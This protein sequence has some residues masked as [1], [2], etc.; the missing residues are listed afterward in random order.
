MFL[1]LDP[2]CLWCSLLHFKFHLF[3]CQHFSLVLFKI[4]FMFLLKFSFCSCILFLILLNYHSVF[5]CSSPVSLKFT[6][7]LYQVIPESPYLGNMYWRLLWSFGGVMFPWFFILLEVF[8][9][10]P[11]HHPSWFWGF[12]RPPM[13]IYAPCFLLPLVTRILHLICLLPDP[14]T[15]QARSSFCFPKDG[16]KFQTCCFSLAVGLVLL[17]VHVL[18]ESVC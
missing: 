11:S 17:S 14:V 2:F 16:G 15:Q 5:Y 8:H 10:Y 1:L 9:C 18:I 13:D 6:L 4:I 7:I 12:L 3:I